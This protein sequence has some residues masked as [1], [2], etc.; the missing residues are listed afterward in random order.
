MGST[1]PATISQDGN[2]RRFVPEPEFYK[3]R[4]PFLGAALPAEERQRFARNPGS[5]AERDDG[6]EQMQDVSQSKEP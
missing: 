3:G 6:D 2:N 4:N 5:V 1:G